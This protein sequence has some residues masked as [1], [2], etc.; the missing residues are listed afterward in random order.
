MPA[1]ALKLGR[2]FLVRLSLLSLPVSLASVMLGVTVRLAGAVESITNARF[3]VELTLPTASFAVICRLLLPSSNAC[4]GVK[5]QMP[6][7]PTTA[8]VNVSFAVTRVTVVPARDVPVIV[9]VLSLVRLSPVSP[10]SEP[11]A[12]AAPGAGGGTP[13]TVTFGNSALA[14]L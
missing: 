1:G 2:A 9:G 3:V 8:E 14:L 13:F 6:P 10:L 5:L 7:P 11:A 4:V 12:S